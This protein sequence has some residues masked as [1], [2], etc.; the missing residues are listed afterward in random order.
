M[1][2]EK[3]TYQVLKKE[4]RFELRLYDP[5]ITSQVKI[6]AEN[7]RD[8]ASRGFSPLANYIFGGNRTRN[9]ISMTSPVTAEPAGE[10]IAMTA[11][12]AVSGSGT[13][14]VSFVV[15]KK[16]TIDTLPVPVD[17]RVTFKEHP[18]R[19]VAA[20]RF[21]G[22]FQQPNFDKHIRKLRDWMEKEGFHEKGEP[23]VAGYTPP[24]TP[25]FLK[26]NE[27]LIEVDE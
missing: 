5:Y 8:A 24:I 25:W 4:G 22:F 6:K 9:K 12:V 16:F 19:K 20:V 3:P 21:S 10:K 14:T 11:P 27:V 7:Y 2:I 15:P 13:Y 1:A 23:V 17:D 18:Q 26:H